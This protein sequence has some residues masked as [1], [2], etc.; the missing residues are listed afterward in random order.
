MFNGYRNGA[1]AL[2]LVVGGGLVLNLFL[3]LDYQAQKACKASPESCQES[4]Y[5]EIGRY[6]D[7]FLGTFVSPSDTLAQWIMALFTIAATI[8]LIFTLVAANKT[9]AAAVDASKAA[10]EANQIMKS[11]NRPWLDAVDFRATN[12]RDEDNEVFVRWDY[13]LNNYGPSPATNIQ[14]F[15]KIIPVDNAINLK[16]MLADWVEEKRTGPESPTGWTVFPNAPQDRFGSCLT[17]CKRGSYGRFLFVATLYDTP[18]GKLSG[19]D[20]QCFRIKSM[21]H[22]GEKDRLI[23]QGLFRLVE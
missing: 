14:V 8:V 23:P 20:A 2:G 4:D 16:S 5:S 17:Q 1:F 19:V 7:G 10:I 21:A 13:I 6:W 9:N 18:D 11:E 3:W 22:D 15:Q 12:I